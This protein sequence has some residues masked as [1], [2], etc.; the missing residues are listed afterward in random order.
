[1]ALVNV[2]D[3]ES[4]VTY[5]D[6]IRPELSH[7][8]RIT[9]D[10]DF[11]CLMDNNVGVAR[12]FICVAFTEDVCSSLYQLSEQSSIA[13][14]STEKNV[15]MFYSVWSL[16]K[17]CGRSVLLSALERVKSERGEITRF[18]TLS[19]KTTMAAN[20]HIGNGAK[21]LKSNVFTDN[22]EYCTD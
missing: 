16:F 17:G 9:G 19:P 5:K 2:R 6:P 18:V 4:P 1:M 20:F 3:Y 8:F 15:A 21:L 22:Y 12:G 13:N 14:G 11:Y 10:R 7:E